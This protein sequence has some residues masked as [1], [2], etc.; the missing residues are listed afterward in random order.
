MKIEDCRLKIVFRT[1]RFCGKSLLFFCAL[2]SIFFMPKVDA[3]FFLTT[4][5]LSPC[6]V[7][8]QDTFYTIHVSSYRI[9]KNAIKEVS[10]LEMSGFEAFYRYEYVKGKAMWYRVYIGRFG[11]RNKAKEMAKALRQKKAISYYNITAVRYDIYDSD[12]KNVFSDQLGGKDA[13]LAGE[14]LDFDFDT[15]LED[16]EPEGRIAEQRPFDFG[17]FIQVT[18]A[19][20]TEHDKAGEHT[21]MVRNTIR[22]EGKWNPIQGT[23]RLRHDSSSRFHALASVEWDYLWFGPYN[24]EED[25]DLDL[26]E[27]YFY[28][29]RKPVDLRVGR[30]IVRWGKTDQISPVDNLNSQ[31]LREFIIPDFEDRKIP[32]WMVRGRLFSDFLTLEGVYIPFF[33]P[34]RIDYFGTDWAV[35]QH[36]KEDVQDSD[37]LTTAF[38]EYIKG[39][40]VNENTPPKTFENGDWGIRLLRTISDWDLGLSYLYSWEDLPYYKSFPIKNL[41]LDGST[42]SDSLVSALAGTTN[43]NEEIEVEY[44]RQHIAGFEFET[45]VKDF[46]FRGEAA[47]FD[48]QSFLTNNLTSTR[49]IVYHYILGVDYSGE[50]DWYINIQF[51]HQILKNYDSTILYFNRNNPSLCGEIS[52]E[53]WEGYFEAELK[54]NFALNQNSFYLSPSI[55]CSYIPNLDITLGLNI[56]E[57]DSDTLMGLYDANDQVYIDFKYHF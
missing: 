20:D 44:R 30:Q 34:S 15:F 11:S 49:K 6:P 16:A 3:D 37:L 26:F 42:S 10:R 22:L 27:G 41:I 25:Y 33:E 31:D 24:D 32:N 12:D 23:T 53:F 1:S 57:G 43:A 56:F 17:G 35:Y 40:Y 46:G 9:H 2:L 50:N 45:T 7:Y 36:L 18:G 47:Y 55:I 5:V 8:A 19:L 14:P 38:K 21:R 51:S 13:D 4:S 29:S 52:K 54:Y 48:K 39:R 28:W